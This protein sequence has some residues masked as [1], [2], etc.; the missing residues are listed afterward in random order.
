MNKN[1][2]WLIPILTLGVFGIL[3]TEMGIIGILP[4]ISQLFNVSVPTAGLLVSGF[5]LV[6]AFAGPT[7]PLLFSKINRK[8][9]MLIALS[10]FTISNLFSIV[11]PTFELLLL[12]RVIPA[13]FHPIYVSMALTVAGQSVPPDQSSKAVAKVF[14][15]VSAGMVLGVP[16]TSFL[17]NTFS[18]GLSMAFFAIVNGLVLLATIL[19][20]PSMPVTER[21]S[22][23]KQISVLK[24]PAMWLSIG[25]VVL[26]NGAVF[27]FFSFLSDFLENVTGLSI[28][29]ITIVLLIYGLANIIGNVIAGRV[30]INNAKNLITILPILVTATSI[31]LFLFGEFSW[32]ALGT[33]LILGILAGIVANVNQY[34]ISSA[35]S[36][37]PDFSNGLFLTAT[38]LGTTIGTSICGF[39][40]S[41]FGTQYS[42]LGS[43]LFLLLGFMG[44]LLRNIFLHKKQL[45]ITNR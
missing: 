25:I 36:D 1:N 44:I 15:G 14:I 10:I 45:L 42:L 30:L 5:A 18:F 24:R 11:A 38:N 28:M 29:L 37:A 27:G 13:A 20:V 9:V 16:V 41:A 39:F 26:L 33:V 43:I 19:M 6:V 22:Y 21:L 17:A 40:I 35:G 4:L 32:I 34:L 31:L 12:A 7:M 8:T 23:G 2:K 3:N